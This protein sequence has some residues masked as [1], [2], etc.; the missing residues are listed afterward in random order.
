MIELDKQ[1]L[2]ALN[3]SDSP[4][5]DE[6]MFTHTGM[7]VW[8]PFFAVCIYVVFRL[9]KWR[10]ALLALGMV[11]L[12]VLL[13]DRISSG[14]FK[15]LFHRF[16]PTHDPEIA[17]L[18]DVVRGYRGGKYGFVSSHAAN[19]FGVVTFLSLLFRRKSLTLGLLFWAFL[20]S[21]TRIY[22]G[23]HFPGDI[24]CGGLLGAMVGWAVF[25]L[26][27][28]VAD[29]VQ[30]GGRLRTCSSSE[31]AWVLATLG[32]T[33]LFIVVWALIAGQIALIE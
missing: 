32:T 3:G 24:V 31:A 8:M 17:M 16:R 23:V 10:E 33:Y 18:V 13:A 25:R 5:W 12:V 4:F 2:L 20:H 9:G 11:A 30:W 14:L 7:W 22:L 15:P 27:G 28:C 1:L 6:F 29:R 19:A 21:Y 26:Y